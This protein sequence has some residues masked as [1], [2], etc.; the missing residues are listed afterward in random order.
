VEAETLACG[1]GAVASGI[2]A[3]VHGLAAPPV[4]VRTSGGERL[5]IH[6][7]PGRKDFGEVYLEGDT[8]W[9]C[10]GR[11]LEEAYRD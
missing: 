9:S 3:T 4:A 6:F 8:S 7:H 1:T 10:D 2:L 5:T 11:I